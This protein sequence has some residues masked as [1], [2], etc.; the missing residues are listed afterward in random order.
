MRTWLFHRFIPR[1]KASVGLEA[2]WTSEPVIQ[3]VA[4]HFANVD[5]PALIMIYECL[6]KLTPWSILLHLLTFYGTRSFI[7]MFTR[8]N[9]WDIV[10]LV[11]SS[12][13]LCNLFL[14]SALILFSHLWSW[15]LTSM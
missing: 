3:S 11:E 1:K 7:T 5:A 13:H 12:P 14:W 2:G 9:N 4:T 6:C 10:Y 15:P 8:A